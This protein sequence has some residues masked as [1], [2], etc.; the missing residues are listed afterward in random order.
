[1]SAPIHVMQ[2]GSPTGL[3]GAERWILALVSHLDRSAIRSSIATIIDEPGMTSAVASEARRMGLEAFEIEASGR[4]NWAAV[5]AL[6]RLVTEEA[7]SILHTHGYKTDLVGLLAVRGT[8]CRIISTPHGWDDS[9]GFRV[10]CYQLIDKASFPFFDAVVPLSGELHDGL[11]RWPGTRRHLR[12]IQNAVDLSELDA[13]GAVA[14]E[15]A[16]WKSQG[17]FVIG[18]IGQL[19]ERKGLDVLLEAFASWAVPEARL[20]LVGDGPQRR[21]LEKL[22]SDRGIAGRVAF[23]GFRSDRLDWLRGFDV[24]VLPSRLEGIPRCLMESLAARVPVI[25]TNI[26]GCTELIVDGETGLLIPPDSP[27]R[28]LKALQSMKSS[29]LRQQLVSRGRALVAERHSA[30]RMAREYQSLYMELSGKPVA[31]A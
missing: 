30:Q 3:Y 7:V 25:A 13:S 11:R 21:Q 6:R 5:S 31:H 24:F 28:L 8:G 15:I 27:E 10:K 23:T 26:P 14:Q 19:I 29:T 4:V 16:E 9:A 20:V 1:M 12:L 2:L 18:Y 17:A 22:A